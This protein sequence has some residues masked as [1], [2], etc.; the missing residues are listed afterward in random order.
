MNP[1]G[2]IYE[3]YE[4]RDGYPMWACY[5]KEGGISGYGMTMQDALNDYLDKTDDLVPDP[6]GAEVERQIDDEL[7]RGAFPDDYSN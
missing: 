7:H 4:S 1:D 6:K 3:P 2:Y 5:R